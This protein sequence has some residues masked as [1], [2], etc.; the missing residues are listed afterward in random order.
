MEKPTYIPQI[1]IQNIIKFLDS[2][3]NS[4]CPWCKQSNWD[5]ITESDS[6][7]TTPVL[8]SPD[9]IEIHNE[10]RDQVKNAKVTISKTDKKQGVSMR[11]R[12][13]NCG[14]ELRFDYFFVLDRIK[15][16]AER[17]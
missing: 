14:C 16:I 10:L 3:G 8:E 5:I 11:L 6:K 13:N 12:C 7:V 17:E 15:K 1:D 2:V 9:T 4:S